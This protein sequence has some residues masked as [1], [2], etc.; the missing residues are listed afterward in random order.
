[1]RCSVDR[2]DVAYDPAF[3]QARVWL[4]GVERWNVVTAD[5]EK[6]FAVI[7][8]LDDQGGIVLDENN[9][10]LLEEFRGAVVI[11]QKGNEI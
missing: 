4:D 9:A 7:F 2:E 11:K 1:M 5:E 10:P 3:A 6:R 8:K